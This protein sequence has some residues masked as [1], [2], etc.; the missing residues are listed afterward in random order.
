MAEKK[1]EP[2]KC[3]YC[4]KDVL[5]NEQ[6]GLLVLVEHIETKNL[7]DI[8]ISCDGECY[9]ILKELRVGEMEIDKWLDINELKNPVLFLQFVMGILD[10]MHNGMQFSDEI[11]ENIKTIIAKSAQYVMRDMTVEEKE[12]A[13]ARTMERIKYEL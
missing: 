1:F 13:I 7:N 6:S 9:D 10:K 2:L 5:T 8:Y 4:K 12:F 3:A 11:L